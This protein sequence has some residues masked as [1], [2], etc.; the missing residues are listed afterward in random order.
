M[1]ILCCGNTECGDAG[2]ASLV[3]HRLR[4]MGIEVREHSGEALSLI[5]AWRDADD[6]VLVDAVATGRRPGAISLWD[7]HT[8]PLA[9]RWFRC[10]SHVLGIAE[11]VGIAR[12]AN[13]LPKRL[14]IF[15][16]ECHHVDAGSKPSIVVARSA[17]RLAEV[18]A[19]EVA[20]CTNLP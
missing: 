1:L 19:D 16:I 10:A 9:R 5:E 11:A 4:S 6:V 12:N 3:A 13:R 7:A 15:G 8:A 18:L 14:R 17:H 20:A 2:A